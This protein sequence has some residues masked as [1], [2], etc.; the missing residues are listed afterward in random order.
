MKSR[1]LK[2]NNVKY[3]VWG[4]QQYKYIII[5]LISLQWLKQE[6]T[7][8]TVFSKTRGVS[9]CER[10]AKEIMITVIKPIYR[11]IYLYIVNSQTQHERC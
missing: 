2:S 9:L 5:Q 7:S 3:A 6:P 10:S 11:D 8:V 1:S 4:Q